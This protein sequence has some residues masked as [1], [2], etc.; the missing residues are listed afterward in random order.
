[1]KIRRAHDRDA[2]VIT[3]QNIALAKESEGIILN[4]QTTLAGVTA[5]LV[6]TTK[7]FYLVAEENNTVIGQLMITFEWSDWRNRSLW[8][9]QSVYVQ[10]PWRKQ[11]VFTE[12]LDHAKEMA[13]REGVPFLRL[14]VHDHNTSAQEVYEKM[15]WHHDPYRMYHLPV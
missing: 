11:G 7:G 9:V 8:W 5:L 12:L 6:D 4:N 14:Y 3:A 2:E 15:G 1:M 13:H 10:E